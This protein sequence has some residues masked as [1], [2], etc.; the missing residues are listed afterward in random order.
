MLYDRWREIARQNKGEIALWDAMSGQY[1]SF[2]QLAAAA[3]AAPSSPGLN[4]VVFA[5]GISRDFIFTVL[6]AWAQ[7]KVLC[8]LEAGQQPLEAG[9]VPSGCVHLKTT[10]ASSGAARAIAFSAA[11]LQADAANIVETMGLRPEAP[12][13]GA[14][15]LAHSYGFSNLVLPLLLHGIPLILVEAPLPEM[16]RR[17]AG[18]VSRVTLPA[19]PALWRAWH[20]ARAIPRNVALAI[21]AGASLP[22]RLE[23]EIFEALGLK[24][25]NFYGSSECGGIAYDRSERP[26]SDA[27][28]VGSAMANVRLEVDD[29]GCLRVRSKAVGLTYWPEPANGLANGSFTT[30]DLARLDGGL[31]FLHGR[32]TDQ[33][34]VAGRKVSPEVIE[35]A[36]S[37]HAHVR[38]CLVF[39]VPHLEHDR[40]ERIVAC[41]VSADGM[42]A[43]ALKQHLLD[44][45]PPWQVP[46]A[47][48]F[49]DSL[50]V[51]Q[52]G[53]L[54]RS[55]WRRRYMEN[56]AAD[57]SRR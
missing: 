25:H 35:R 27:S 17:A 50:Q 36:L 39:G 55:E 24:L 57:A 9:E 45:L 14:I 42:D 49:V 44:V 41:V 16:V 26:R 38:D 56:V 8:P 33:I 51:N 5:K 18:L 40:S 47:W 7:G 10:S 32:Q 31:V 46:R 12:N 34:N 19:V 15:S 43:D 53:K 52:R 11:Q 30:S 28:C 21:S 29:N 3:E 13:V 20:Q 1:W 2:G 37:S 48:W 22:L 4:P 6:Q 54:P 23:E